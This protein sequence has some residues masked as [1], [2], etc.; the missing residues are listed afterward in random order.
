MIKFLLTYKSVFKYKS[1]NCALAEA[2]SQMNIYL[3]LLSILSA[4]R[5]L[6]PS[7]I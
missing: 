1:A 7:E 6:L 2:Q 5:N 4:I 3:T